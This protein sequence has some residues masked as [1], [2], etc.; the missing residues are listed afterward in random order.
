VQTIASIA[1][2][3]DFAGVTNLLVERSIRHKSTTKNMHFPVWTIAAHLLPS[4]EHCAS[5]RAINEL[6]VILVV[7][8]LEQQAVPAARPTFSKVGGNGFQGLS[9][10][11]IRRR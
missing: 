8:P 7:T 6:A 1:I 2:W 4:S 10:F 5:F 11:R 3:S 9:Q